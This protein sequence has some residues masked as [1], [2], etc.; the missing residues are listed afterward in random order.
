MAFPAPLQSLNKITQFIDITPNWWSLFRIISWCM[1]FLIG[2]HFLAPSVKQ[3]LPFIEQIEAA[4][5]T[6]LAA[7][8]SDPRYMRHDLKKL[9]D[10]SLLWVAASSIIITEQEAFPSHYL[11]AEIQKFLPANT[12]QFVSLK[13]ARRVIDTYTM[14]TDAIDRKPGTLVIILNPFWIMND[15]A[16]FYQGNV[17]NYGALSWLN[18]TDKSLI[19]LLA[20]PGNLLWGYAGQ[21]H[22]M[23]ANAYDYHAISQEKL[24]Q[25][26]PKADKI[27]IKEEKQEIIPKKKPEKRKLTYNQPLMLWITGRTDKSDEFINT[28]AKL[29]QIESMKQNSVQPG[30]WGRKFLKQMLEKVKRSDIPT[31]I[32]IAPLS[33]DLER[34]TEAYEA[35]RLVVQ[36]VREITQPYESNRLKFIYDIPPEIISTMTYIDYIHL[37]NSGDFPAYLGKQI[38]SL[39]EG[40]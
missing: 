28:N 7:S 32:Y 1:L 22:S 12:R 3:R 26:L 9:P 21:H 2:F 27:K 23:I 31:F 40:K 29:W 20:S 39:M 25:E 6:P 30:N 4:V 38:S 16:L 14:V 35:Y 5:L 15:N 10:N 34:S 19:A 18:A 37:R 24:S 36:Q 33:L 8:T 11:P 13:V 17:I